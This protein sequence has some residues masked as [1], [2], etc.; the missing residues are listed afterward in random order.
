MKRS[1]PDEP[2][3]EEHEPPRKRSASTRAVDEP[4]DDAEAA[5][6]TA[7]FNSAL[8][9]RIAR[10]GACRACLARWLNIQPL[11]A[12]D[13]VALAAFLARH[14]PLADYAACT[15]CCGLLDPQAGW[16]TA[17]SAA[18]AEKGYEGLRGARLSPILPGTL[19]LLE[20]LVA[21]H[22]YE[23][24]HRHNCASARV[25]LEA[26][27]FGQTQRLMPGVPVFLSNTSRRLTE[28]RCDVHV[29]DDKTK[30]ELWPMLKRL[31][32]VEGASTAPWQGTHKNEKPAYR[33]LCTWLGE[34]LDSASFR[35]GAPRVLAELASAR[36]VLGTEQI[37]LV[38]DSAFVGGRY[39]KHDREVSH[40]PFFVGAVQLAETSVNSLLEAAIA[41]LFGVP[42]GSTN[43]LSAGREDLDVRML[44]SGRPFVLEIKDPR[45]IAGPVGTALQHLVPEPLDA[46]GRVSVSH[47]H[48][49]S[50]SST[51]VLRDGEDSKRK[52]YR[53]VV[54]AS[55][56]L[57][58]AQ[59]ASLNA[60]PELHLP[61]RTPIRVLHR[62]SAAERDKVIHSMRA[63]YI[64][65]RFFL[66]DLETSAGT[67]VKEFVH[68]DLGRC[69]PNLGGLL[70]PGIACDLLQL[71]V[72]EV[73][74]PFP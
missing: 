65:P 18:L 10:L 35:A 3:H 41:P 21:C 17:L 19:A 4:R 36:P 2:A 7:E 69:V 29:C 47:L 1:A 34:C 59:V 6:P 12:E 37:T 24:Y 28:L 68:S 9:E 22:V 25:S 44:G 71:D 61:Q 55:Q 52:A 40:S 72:M 50:E 15:I 5:P 60:I 8:A 27:V 64:N 70:G 43:I 48:V 56:P 14:G 30:E 46:L 53:C 31:Q 58:P 23:L 13:D 57:Q 45:R 42:P 49:A 20:F 66:L 32:R 38:R 67:Y 62:R 73:I 51:A 26:A 63:S 11:A 33:T 16:V 74:M 54:W 39:C